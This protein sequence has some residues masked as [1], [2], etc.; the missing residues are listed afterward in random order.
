MSL[1]LPR[2]NLT[3]GGDLRAD[4]ELWASRLIAEIERDARDQATPAKATFSVSIAAPSATLTDVS[5]LADVRN[6]LG[7]LFGSLNKK[8]ILRTKA[9]AE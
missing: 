7:E 6:F 1:N 8:G 9:G 3:T 2:L 4:L 5:A